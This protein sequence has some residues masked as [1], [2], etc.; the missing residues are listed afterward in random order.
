[1][2]QLD[3]RALVSSLL[4]GAFLGLAGTGIFAWATPYDA[5]IAGIHTLLGC[6]VVI[7]F[8]FHL[9]NN[10]RALVGYMTARR[11]RIAWA[12]A[13]P[14]SLAL[15]VLLDLPPASSVIETG[16]A[17]RNMGGVTD[18]SFEVIRTRVGDET[19]LPIRLSVRAGRHYESDPQP[20]FL[21]LSYTSVPQMAF[22]AET[23]DGQFLGTLY[24]TRALSD[25]SF[26]STDLFSDEVIRRPEALP[27]WS[28]RRGIRYED[29]LA[30]PLPGNTDLD[31]ITAPTPLGHYDLVSRTPEEGGLV[32]VFMEINRSYDFNAVWHPARFPDD[33]VYSG[34]GSSGQPSIV[35]M[36]E[37]DVAAGERF[38]LLEPVG[39]GHPSGRDGSLTADLTGF[40]TAL[41]LVGPVIAEIERPLPQAVAAAPGS[42]PR[43]AAGP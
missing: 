39:H 1:M 16:Y 2:N 10:L 40:D 24:V 9:A 43:V 21:G 17:L 41:E 15:L 30:V 25:S 13:L 11:R 34:S 37:I 3:R 31:G 14:G 28:H 5:T 7:A 36:A 26:R 32:R 18:G 29:G 20:L 42:A 23:S 27:V 33:P 4:A 19:G 6:A 8:G 22:W 12:M 38:A 35:Y